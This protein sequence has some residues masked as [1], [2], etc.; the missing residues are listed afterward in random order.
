[1]PPSAKPTTIRVA[2]FRLASACT[3]RRHKMDV[4]H[5]KQGSG[6]P[7]AT[8]AGRVLLYEALQ[9]GEVISG[10]GQRW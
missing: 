9:A 2:R 5:P 3:S 7:M 4:G 1:M 10:G 8:F 6:S